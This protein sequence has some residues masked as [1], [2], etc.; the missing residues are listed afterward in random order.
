MIQTAPS[1]VRAADRAVAGGDDLAG[2]AAQAAL[3]VRAEE[4]EVDALD[5]VEHA[6]VTLGGADLAHDAGGAVRAPVDR[7]VGLL[8]QRAQTAGHVR[9]VV[10]ER[11]RRVALA[12]VVVHGLGDGLDGA[13]TDLMAVQAALA[14]LARAELAR[15]P[16]VAGVGLLVGLQ[17]G[18]SPFVHAE[19]DGPVQRG[20]TAVAL[21]ARG[22]V[23]D[24]LGS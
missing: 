16:D 12:P 22:S 17:E 23:K 7:A 15:G 1:T 13:A 2:A 4:E 5:R 11:R 19:L 6:R 8:H 9:V 18:D 20:R 14:D 3:E 24:S 10:V 21:R